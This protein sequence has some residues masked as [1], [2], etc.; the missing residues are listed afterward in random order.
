MIAPSNLSDVQR[1]L[2]AAKTHRALRDSAMQ[3]WR[4]VS[5]AAWAGLSG[6]FVAS[7][8]HQ[9]ENARPDVLGD[10]AMG[11]EALSFGGEV[12]VDAARKRTSSPSIIDSMNFGSLSTLRGRGL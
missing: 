10:E 11:I 4:E 5:A 2:I 3:T 8:I 7:V 6:R 9:R 12:E 1:H